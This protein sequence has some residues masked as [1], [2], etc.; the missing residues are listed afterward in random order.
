MNV[1]MR[2]WSVPCFYLARIWTRRGLHS[3]TLSSSYLPRGVGSVAEV[4]T[5]H[6]L[7]NRVNEWTSCACEP[8]TVCSSSLD[9]DAMTR[10]HVTSMLMGVHHDCAVVGREMRKATSLPDDCLPMNYNL[11]ARLAA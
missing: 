4:V 1:T 6:L 7:I 9:R 10:R 5:G 2:L 8:R 11:S 3:I